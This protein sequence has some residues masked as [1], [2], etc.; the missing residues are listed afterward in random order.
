M[1]TAGQRGGKNLSSLSSQRA[2]TT[3][4]RTINKRDRGGEGGARERGGGGGGGRQGGEGCGW[5][6]KQT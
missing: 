6:V 2:T 3:C 1:W 5:G 4:L